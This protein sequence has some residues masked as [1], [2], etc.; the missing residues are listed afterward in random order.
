MKIKGIRIVRLRGEKGVDLNVVVKIENDRWRCAPSVSRYSYS[1]VIAYH[2]K[3][4]KMIFVYLL[5]YMYNL[6]NR[7]I[8]RE[9]KKS[10]LFSFL[11]LIFFKLF[12]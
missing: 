10:N 4:R 3:V 9:C 6:N 12:N 8:E 7:I 1:N 2:V 11:S 5:L